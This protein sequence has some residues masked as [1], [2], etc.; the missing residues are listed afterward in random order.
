LEIRADG[1]QVCFDFD[2]QRKLISRTDKLATYEYLM[3]QVGMSKQHADLLLSRTEK[4]AAL[5]VYVEQP[6][7][8]QAGVFDESMWSGSMDSELGV[9]VMEGGRSQVSTVPGQYDAAAAEAYQHQQGENDAFQQQPISADAIQRASDTGQKD[10]FDA[11]ALGALINIHDISREL[12]S[13]MP[14][15]IQAVDKLGRVL[16]LT[17]WHSEDFQERYGKQESVDLEDNI[18]SV[19]ELLGDTVLDLRK[20]SPTDEDLLGGGLI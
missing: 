18:R 17:Y 15:L 1:P 16:F 11:G 3:G 10:I 13:Y 7:V 20:K 12:D 9:P 5:R 4:S 6:K 19:F 8:K 2:S 14:D